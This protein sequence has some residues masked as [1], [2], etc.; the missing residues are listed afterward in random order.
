MAPYL[1][2]PMPLVN[3]E[4][5]EKTVQGKIQPNDIS[6]HYP[7]FYNGVVV[8]TKSGSSYLLAIEPDAFDNLLDAYHMYVK[9]NPGKFGILSFNTQPKNGGLIKV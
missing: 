7:G 2:V 6:Y 3:T 9:H 1:L 5:H 4:K 8:V